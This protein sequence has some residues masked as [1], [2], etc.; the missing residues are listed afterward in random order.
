MSAAPPA[1]ITA[2]HP[3]QVAGRVI[4]ALFSLSILVVIAFFVLDE[5]NARFGIMALSALIVV[6]TKPLT[7]STRLFTRIPWVGWTVDAALVVAFGWAAI[8]FFRVKQELY[9]GFFMANPQN[10][11]AGIM[12]MAVLLLLT[13]RAWGWSLVIMALTF[14]GFGFVG[15]W[16]PGLLEHWGMY[17]GDFMQIAWYSFDG[18]FGRTTGLVADTVLVFL[19][20]GAVLE[21]TGAG[22]SLIHISTAL[23][24]RIRGGAAHAAIV[25]SGVFGMMSGSVAANIAGTGVFTIPMIKRQGFSAN[26]A[27]AVETSASSGGQLTPPIMAAAVFVMADLV[28]MPFA[29]VI[30]GAALPALFKYIGLFAQ[31][32]A[33]AIR[34]DIEPLPEDQVPVLTRRDWLNSLLVALPIAALMATFV[35]GKSPA[36]AG[37]VGVLTALVTGF[38]L[39]PDFRR[40]PV[41]V[42]QALAD[43]GIQAAQIMLAVG[44]IG[45]VLAV[46]NET[47]VAIR[48]ATSIAAVGDDFLLLALILAMFGALILGMGLPTLPA[49][50]IIA[51]MIAPAIIKAGVPPLAAHMFVLYFAV[52]S[53]IVP[54]IA[55]GCYIA[56]P[57]AGGHPLTT[58]FI[59]LRLSIVGLLVPYVFVYSPSLLLVAGPFSWAELGSTILRLLVAIW[60]LASAFG[61][62]D[63]R[64]GKLGLAQ[65]AVRLSLGAGAMIPLAPIWAT[66]VIGAA[67]LGFFFPRLE[68]WKARPQ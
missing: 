53:S 37:L 6:L 4:A 66:A 28:G 22:E 24:A 67:I 41:R 7:Q 59:A 35:V 45:I 33:S 48:F 30:V 56:A 18:V 49:Y 50:L 68:L 57:I 32:Y 16:L 9:S 44:V 54:P 10:I 12:G 58:A 51:I 5:A 26:F 8:W 25:A 65:R 27:G 62:A 52:Y 15:P 2:R 11:T 61:G 3:V 39:N 46:V 60:M 19:I 47:G 23:T 55:Y 1:P 31:V 42:L 17:L 36:V 29:M 64:V 40:E 34:M 20:F 43:G 13:V 63:P 21:R 14:V 38:V